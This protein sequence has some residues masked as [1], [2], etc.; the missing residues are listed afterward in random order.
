MEN[1]GYKKLLLMLLASF[2]VM[3]AVMFANVDSDRHVYLSLTRTYMA[4]LMVT[5]MA[6][7]MLLLMG[8]MFQ[9]KK[10]NAVIAGVSVLVFALSLTLLRTQTPV[11]DEQYMKA[12]IPHH[13]SAIMVSKHADIRDPEVKQLS[14]QIIKSQE[15]EIAQM[16]RI[17]E[18]MK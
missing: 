13:S 3:Y 2:V 7:L 17:L 9:N 12:M 14:Q 8:K 15:E 11:A 6:L 16:K 10:R 1:T 4:L 5:P 18:R